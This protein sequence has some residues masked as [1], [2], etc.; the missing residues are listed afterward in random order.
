VAIA[1]LTQELWARATIAA[2]LAARSGPEAHRAALDAQE[3]EL[4]RQQVN[5][6]R[7]ELE[8][9]AVIYGEL[10]AQAAR[11]E[12]IAR[13]A[14]ARLEESE[15]RERRHLRDLGSARQ[16]VAELHAAMTQLR[17]QGARPAP[18]RRSRSRVKVPS[19]KPP[20]RRSHKPSLPAKAVRKQGASFRRAT[21]KRPS[22]ARRTH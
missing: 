20:A 1:E 9:E 4:L 6:L 22:K 15:A 17:E 10:R 2:A 21:K 8:R 13:S 19:S 3:T 12:A 11:H 16:R 7:D 14:L 18:S 5:H